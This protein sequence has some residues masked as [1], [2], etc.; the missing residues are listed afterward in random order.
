ML[1]NRDGRFIRRVSITENVNIVSHIKI[2]ILWLHNRIRKHC[3]VEDNI[4]WWILYAKNNSYLAIVRS[5]F[6]IK[7][8][9]LL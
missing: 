3:F 9:T 5:S 8:S 1:Y 7:G 2:L 4:M 6:F